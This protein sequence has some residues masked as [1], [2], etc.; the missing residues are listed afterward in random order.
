[1]TYLIFG[2]GCGGGNRMSVAALG[3]TDTE[4]DEE[5][6]D[7]ANSRQTHRHERAHLR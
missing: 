2:D 4:F 5:T 6:R 1:M 3:G 7:V